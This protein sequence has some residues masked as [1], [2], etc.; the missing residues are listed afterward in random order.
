[1]TMN[2]MVGRDR[3]LDELLVEAGAPELDL[4]VIDIDGNDYEVLEGLTVRP[5]VI[6]V[7]V[8][9]GHSPG[10]QDPVPG[11][12]AAENVGQPLA[13]FAALAKGRGYR[14][15]AYSGNAFFVREDVADGLAELTPQAAYDSF[16]RHLSHRERA[17]LFH[18]NRG[19]VPPFH[20]FG[21]PW[22]SR[23]G[24]DLGR[25]YV[26]LRYRAYALLRGR[27]AAG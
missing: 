18:V 23:E 21:N 2:C 20:R 17:W 27:R 19:E 24:L 7:E 22:L 14:L 26:G 4:L 10:D 6:C 15:V 3:P 12:V 16:L 9:A 8:N 11:E 1:V 13:V 5:R 25:G